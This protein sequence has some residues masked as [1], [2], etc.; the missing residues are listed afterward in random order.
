[1]KILVIGEKCTDYFI[2][3][4][5][6][7]LS[8]EA[9]IPVFT[10]KVTK[11]NPGM[12][13]NVV[14]NLKSICKENNTEIYSIHQK[15]EITKTR[16]IDEKSNHSF[17]RV[18]I[19]E[20]NIDSFI[21]NEIV[22]TQVK[23]MDIVIVSDYDKGFLNKNDLCLIAS[24]SKFSILDTKKYLTSSIID[25]FTFIKLNEFEYQKQLFYFNEYWLNKI[26]ITLGSKGAKHNNNIY[27]SP[28]PK[29][30]IDVSGAGDTFT[31]A[32]AYKFLQSNNI[33][34][35]IT[36]ANELANIVISKRG[37]STP[38]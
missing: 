31:A 14:E 8:P 5:A 15:N 16:Y 13:G 23:N 34:T 33:S 7:R 27:P 29:Q 36:F 12:A 6:N 3:G 26:I 2:Y 37:V 9:P 4:E 20:E 35:A 28:S 30:T 25:K 19:G 32:F 18:D 38:I 17:L 21:F 24:Y 10:P 11:T 22:E 1:M